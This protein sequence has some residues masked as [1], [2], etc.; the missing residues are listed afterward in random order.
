[1]AGSSLHSRCRRHFS[2]TPLVSSS[3]VRLNN[4]TVIRSNKEWGFVEIHRSEIK[5]NQEEP[6]KIE[7]VPA[8]THICYGRI[9]LG[10]S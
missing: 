3:G 7:L 5:K 4:E 2:D 8:R 10:V 6:M 1:M 9:D